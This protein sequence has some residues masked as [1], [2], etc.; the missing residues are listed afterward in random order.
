MWFTD[1]SRND[2][3]K[4]GIGRIASDGTFTEFTDGLPRDAKPYS[5]AAGPDGN[6]WF[7]DWRGVVVGKI[8]PQGLITEY[9]ASGHAHRH[10]KGIAFGRGGEPW[11]LA[12]DEQSGNYPPLL[13][14]VTRKGTV[15]TQPLPGGMDAE[16]GAAL[17]ADVDGNVWF[18]GLT[19]NTRRG[20]LVEHRGR[21][22]GFLRRP[23]DMLSAALP[24]CPNVA[25]KSVAIGADGNP[26]FTTLYLIYKNSPHKYL[27]TLKAGQ[28]NLYPLRR[29]GL[30][31]VAYPSALALGTD[32]FWVAGSEP[33]ADAGGLWHFDSRRGQIVYV[34]PH[35]PLALAVDAAGNPWFT[36]RFRGEPSRIIEVLTH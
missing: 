30:P 18:I 12:D 36:T 1:L 8:T 3:R 15:E 20:E 16:V 6:M 29:G 17:T 35:A 25:P 33:N 21:S 27:G 7:S 9:A 26:W 22:G 10:A 23:L 14:H 19:P 11:I 34:L 24:C 2:V 4:P 5:I 13:A 28:V 32:G 31:Y